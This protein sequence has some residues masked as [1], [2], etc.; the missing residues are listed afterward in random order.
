MPYKQLLESNFSADE[1]ANTIQKASFEAEKANL[2]K[3]IEALGAENLRL[4]DFSDISVKVAEIKAFS[5]GLSA[6]FKHLIVLGTG[7]STLCGQ[8]LTGIKSKYGAKERVTFVDNI[9]PLT[10]QELAASLNYEETAVLTISKSGGTLEV[11]SQL[12]FFLNRYSEKLGLASIKEHFFAISDAPGSKPNTLRSIASQY[13]IN[14]LEHENV[15]GRFSIFTNVGLIPAAFLGLDI[16]K[17]LQ[18]AESV[19]TKLFDSEKQNSQPAIGALFNHSYERK[20]Y[21]STVMMP[22]VDRLRKFNLWFSQ[23]WAE[24]LGKSGYGLTPIRALG[25]LDQHS[26]LQQFLDGKKDKIFNVI[27]TRDETSYVPLDTKMLNERSLDFLDGKNFTKLINTSAESTIQSLKNNNR[28]VRIFELDELNEFTMGALCMHFILETVLVAKLAELNPFD[29]P[30]V[31][32]GKN[33]TLKI[34]KAS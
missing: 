29:Q 5:E 7:G 20:G 1:N 2:L 23:I 13:G 12:I 32:E 28:P 16:T 4:F 25:S 30:A 27:I 15:G 6:K 31:E 18:G 34:L 21:N 8:C 33:I 19:K 24:S 10:L 26:Q 22:Y 17:I 9:D 14:V 3:I 11:L